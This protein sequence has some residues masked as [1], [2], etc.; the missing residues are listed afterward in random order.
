MQLKTISTYMYRLNIM[1]TL[2]NAAIVP[3]SRLNLVA[4][5]VK[6][7]KGDPGG[8][9]PIGIKGEKG[10]PGGQ[11]GQKGDKGSKGR[12]SSIEFPLLVADIA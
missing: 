9:G 11:K 3:L 6:G 5:G 12:N 4:I 7:C 1:C 2:S 8:P 10:D